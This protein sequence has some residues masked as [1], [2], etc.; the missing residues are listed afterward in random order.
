[1]NLKASLELAVRLST[2]TNVGLFYEGLHQLRLTLYY[3]DTEVLLY[4]ILAS[5]NQTFNT[6]ILYKIKINI[7][8][9]G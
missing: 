8:S 1:M 7:H 5:Y 9:K 3:T 4:H 6:K 2:F